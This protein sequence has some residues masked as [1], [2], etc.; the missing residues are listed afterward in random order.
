MV[1]SLNLRQ[2]NRAVYKESTDEHERAAPWVSTARN[3]RAE[4]PESIAPPER[5]G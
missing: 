1:G 3:V 2:R 5:A 4:V